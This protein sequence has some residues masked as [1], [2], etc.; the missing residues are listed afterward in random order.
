M[1]RQLIILAGGAGTRLKSRLGDLPKPM[2]PIAGKPLL[3]H[4]VELARK[5]G[6]TDLIFFVHYRADLI[7]RHFGNGNKFGVE[8]RHIL[9][10]APLG[11]AGAVIAGFQYLA[12]RFIV[13]Y[14]DTMVNVDLNRL[15]DAHER[16]RADG[17]LLLHPNDH[18]L[19]SDL[20]EVDSK[21]RI[22]A[23]HNRPHPEN[24]W[25]QNLVNAGLYVLEKD[26]LPAFHPSH[27]EAAAPLDFGK[28]VF[29]AMLQSGKTLLGYNS[30]EFIKDIG[31]PERYDRIN[32][33]FAS[34]VVE[35]SS[36][37]QPQRAVFL[38][39]DGTIVHDKDCLRRAED[40]DLLPHV[41]EAIRRLNLAG[42][43]AIVVTNQPV[44]AKGFCD[45]MELQRTHNKLETLLGREHAFLDRIHFCPHHPQKGFPGERPDL[46]IECDCRKPGIGMIQRAAA[47]LNIDLSQSW[48]IGDTTTD[49]QTAKN[50]GI[51]SILV[52]TGHAGKDGK[53]SATPDSVAENL[54]DA[55]NLILK[56]RNP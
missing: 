53:Y 46:K 33:Q 10:T 39:R 48:M 29:P 5:Y 3:E 47:E 6:F 8:I 9:E 26:A 34:G 43:K 2:V 40:L 23:F 7:E 25:R 14:G 16:A 11:T 32:A 31:T 18:P 51:R 24:V 45:E 21:S 38:D 4:Q 49:L 1:S 15:W 35:R 17:T 44:I 27:G 55:V 36:L 37:A 54:L 41:P 19:D 13:L 30:P 50:A 20:V 12:R 42:W 52:R 56:E 22:L 28:D